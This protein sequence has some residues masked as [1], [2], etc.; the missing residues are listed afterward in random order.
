MPELNAVGS[1]PNQAT[2]DSRQFEAAEQKHSQNQQKWTLS[3][4]EV[5]SRLQ[6]CKHS[7]QTTPTCVP[8][9]LPNITSPSTQ[10]SPSSFA[11]PKASKA[12]QEESYNSGVAEDVSQNRGEEWPELSALDIARLWFTYAE[13]K[14]LGKMGVETESYR[15]CL[16]DLKDMGLIDHDED[17]KSMEEIPIPSRQSFSR[18]KVEKWLERNFD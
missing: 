1:G 7:R 11:A 15:D 6:D 2:T 9:S 10:L 16:K 5:Q 3:A 17:N 4:Q 8:Q 14:A 18:G 13:K 12:S